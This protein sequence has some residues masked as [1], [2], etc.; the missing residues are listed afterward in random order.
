M[1]DKRRTPAPGQTLVAAYKAI[2]EECIDR[3]PSGMRA[4]IAA[5]LGKHK[6][7]V[8]QLINPVYP[9][10]IPARHLPAIFDLCHFSP[11]ERQAFLRAY[12]AAHPGRDSEGGRL[13][14]ARPRRK[15]LTVEVPLLADAR[16]Q[17]A[18]E[19]LFQELAHRLGE[20]LG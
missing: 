8:T 6:S 5:A 12:H 17:R 11:E 16:K 18:L 10:P 9:M 7:F 13:A 20:L 3:R 15:Q 1:A 4:R 14:V 2:L 19:A